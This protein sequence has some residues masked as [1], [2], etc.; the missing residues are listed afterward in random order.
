[1]INK[2][3]KAEN[4][5][6][7]I[8][9]FSS[10]KAIDLVKIFKI[11]GKL[12]VKKLGSTHIIANAFWSSEDNCFIC[13]CKKY[14]DVIGIGETEEE[15]VNIFFELLEEYLKDKKQDKLIKN[16]GGR[17]KKT[18]AKLVYNV[19]QEIKAFIELEA[20]RND[21]NQ[22]V[23]VEK[24]IKFYQEAKKEELSKYYDFL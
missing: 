22:G 19:P 10:H 7:F 6:Y 14:P 5:K 8:S 24:I 13:K 20:T 12:I 9:N 15:A 4:G 3:Y 18:N 16:K 2:K 1:M 17:P 21:V 11:T 23:I